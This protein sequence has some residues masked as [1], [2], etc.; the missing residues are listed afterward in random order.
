MTLV[1]NQGV[2]ALLQAIERAKINAN[3]KGS[4]QIKY[5]EGC[6]DIFHLLT[7]KDYQCSIS[8]RIQ[9][10]EECIIECLNRAQVKP[11]EID[12]IL[13][14]GGSSNNL[15]VDEL[16]ERV[17]KKGKIQSSDIFTSVVAGLS[18][19]AADFYQK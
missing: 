13:K 2:F 17:F 18:I 14:T 15:F 4:G 5:K 9:E 1:Q 16:L 11:D 19:A 6:I 7:A 3:D 12:I 8:V 10:A